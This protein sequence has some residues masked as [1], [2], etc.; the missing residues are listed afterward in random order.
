M[1]AALHSLHLLRAERA[2]LGQGGGA[3]QQAGSLGWGAGQT[4]RQQQQ[5][6]RVGAAGEDSWLRAARGG[7]QSFRTAIQQP[8]SSSL[9]AEDAFPASLRQSAG[10]WRQCYCGHRASLSVEVARSCR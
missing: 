3:N 8:E 6:R 1:I 9:D 4:S 7:S 2:Y 10:A 5:K